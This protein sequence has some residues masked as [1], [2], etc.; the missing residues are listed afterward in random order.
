MPVNI[1]HMMRIKLYQILVVNPVIYLLILKKEI[2]E[3]GQHPWL[4]RNG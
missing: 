1:M 3:A 4:S 2:I